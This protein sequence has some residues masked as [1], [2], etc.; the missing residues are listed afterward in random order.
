MSVAVPVI[1]Y[2]DG[3]TRRIYL[4]QG[5]VDLYPIEDLY[6]EYRYMR[7]NDESLRVWEPMLKAEGNVP[8]GAGAFTPRYVVLLLGTK[9]VPYD[10]PDQL[11]QLGDM[12]TDD[13]DTDPSLYD[14]SGLTTAKPIFIKPSEAETIQLNSES[15]EYSSFNGAISIDQDNNTG[16]AAAGTTFPAG[17]RQ[18]PCL[19]TADA[20]LIAADRGIASIDVIGNITLGAGDDFEGFHFVGDST[21]K[22]TITILDAANVLDSEFSH[23]TVTGILDGTTQIDNAILTNLD[24]VDGQISNCMIGPGEVELGVATTANMFNCFSAVPG[25][26]TP[27]IDMNGTGVIGLRGYNGGV[28]FRNYNGNGSHSIDLVSGQIKLDPATITSGTFVCRGVGKLIDASTNDPIPTGPWNG[29]V[30][31]VNEL[32]NRTTIAEAAQ[33]SKA[34]YLDSVN[35][36]AGITDPIGLERDPVDNLADALIIAGKRGT[37]RIFIVNDFTFTSSVNITGY[38]FLGSDNQTTV[39]TFEPGAILAYCEFHNFRM[40]G[41]IAGMIELSDCVLTDL[42]SIGVVPSSQTLI[43]RRCEFNGNI[44]FPANYSGTVV[45]IDSY[46]GLSGGSY[47]VL[48]YGGSNANLVMRGYMGQVELK[49]VTQGNRLDIT[50]AGGEIELDSSVTS[51]D[52]HFTG[53]GLLIDHS[54]HEEILSGT[55]NTGVTVDNESTS[56]GTV[57]DKV[58]TK[59]LP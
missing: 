20:Q 55:W 28:E 37:N 38:E 52:I 46:T 8:K 35:G 23:C 3:A 43:V 51:A 7:A 32:I 58:W 41:D 6:H 54:T 48:D 26:S 16:L 45:V 18:R 4:R 19:N 10:E 40:T 11:N 27:V 29:G 2:I 31:I 17:T 59:V 56:P 42:G 14:I 49:N 5:V 15:I 22:S 13:P 47:A 1:D 30:T 25:S 34:V 9:V 12:I 53:T 21:L 50:M 44:T 24:F 36:R 57:T 33:Y 39:L